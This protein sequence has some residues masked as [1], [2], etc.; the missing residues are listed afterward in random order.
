MPKDDYVY[1]RSSRDDAQGVFDIV[2]ASV[3]HLAPHPYSQEVVD[4]W[5]AGRTPENYVSDC[6]GQTIWI[7]ELYGRPVGFSQGVPGEVKRL[8][9]D[10]DHA[11]HGLGRALFIRA[12]AD[13]CPNGGGR[14]FIE[15]TLNAVP[16]YEK[17]GFRKTGQG[18]FAGRAAHLPV[19]DVVYLEA[20][21]EAVAPSDETGD[22]P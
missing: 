16:F 19:I 1:R 13:A 2:S 15:A 4:S 20:Q 7:A 14:V 6:A 11:A 3:R 22:F 8:F 18:V 12:L 21:I 17:W 9:V 5:M 10:A